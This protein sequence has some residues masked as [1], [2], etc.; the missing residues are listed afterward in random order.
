MALALEEVCRRAMAT[1]TSCTTRPRV[2]ASLVIHAARHND[3]LDIWAVHHR[4]LGPIPIDRV[5]AF[6]CD[7]TFHAVVLD[8]LGLPV[9]LGRDHRHATPAQR[10]ALVA[11]DGCCTFPGCDAHLGWLDAHHVVHWHHGGSTDLDNLVLLCR[12]HHRVAHR[13]GWSLTLGADGWTRG[14]HPTATRSGASATTVSGPARR[15][16]ESCQTPAPWG[17]PTSRRS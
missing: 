5:P 6:L 15:R 8:S 7:A 4:V 1:D 17:P 2:E 9:D 14:P 13:R 3:Q 11:R 12:R 16:S 10:R